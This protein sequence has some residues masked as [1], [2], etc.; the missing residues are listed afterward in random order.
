MRGWTGTLNLLAKGWAV[1]PAHAG[2][3]RY[4]PV[5]RSQLGMRFPRACGDGPLKMLYP[6]SFGCVF[7]AHAGMDRRN[8]RKN[9]R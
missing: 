4:P 1:F 5:E 7:P 3:D 8:G 6:T 9:C 2:M